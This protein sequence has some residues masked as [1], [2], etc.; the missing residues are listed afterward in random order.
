[1]TPLSPAIETRSL[2]VSH[3]GRWVVKDLDVKFESGEFVA[4]VGPNGAGKTTLLRA[5]AGLAERWG[6]LD[7][8]GVPIDRLDPQSR[9]RAIAYL[10]QAH[11]FHWPMSVADIVALGRLPHGSGLRGL[12]DADRMAIDDAM[13]ETETLDLADRPVTS[14]SGGEQSR[15]AI[16]RALAVAAPVFLAD[17]P[18]ASLDPRHQIRMLEAL[19]H[20]A[21]DGVAV[22][23]VLQDL[24]LAARFA[25][26]VLV[27]NEGA[28]VADGPPNKVLTEETL[29]RIFGVTGVTVRQNGSA[30]VTP[31]SAIGRPKKP[32]DG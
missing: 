26:R 32:K 4:I 1:M 21:A 23:A 2:A 9:A 6:E 28:I 14:L 13:A 29:R 19:R 12:S 24:G 25:D 11:V 16:A 10:P 8:D 22:I 3:D 7:I 27:M 30:I 20:Q 15:V 18:A 31:W 17:E 5:L